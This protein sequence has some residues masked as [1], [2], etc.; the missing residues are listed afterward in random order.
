MPLKCKYND[1]NEGR[2]M[3]L[4]LIAKAWQKWARN[5]PPKQGFC[6][7]D[8]MWTQKCL[9]ARVLDWKRITVRSCIVRDKVPMKQEAIMSRQTFCLYHGILLMLPSTSCFEE[10]CSRHISKDQHCVNTLIHLRLGSTSAL[11]ACGWDHLSGHFPSRTWCLRGQRFCRR[12]LGMSG[13]Q[14]QTSLWSAEHCFAVGCIQQIHSPCCNC[15]C[16][17]RLGSKKNRRSRRG[18]ATSSS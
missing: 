4:V 9:I 18:E 3:L 15:N 11:F 2:C 12:W 13:S 6:Q 17:I 5:H 7:K 8:D 16:S 1:V 10:A 14:S